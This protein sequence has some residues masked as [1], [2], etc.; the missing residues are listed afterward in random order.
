VR[1]K[2][3][4]TEDGPR[5][6]SGMYARVLL[7]TGERQ[8]ATLVNKDALVLGGPQPIVFVVD[9]AAAAK[10]GKVRPVPVKLGTA[11]ENFIQV[12]GALQPGQ[13]V[14]VQG[15]ERLQPGQDVRFPG[16]ASP[17]AGATQESPPVGTQSNTQ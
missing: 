9:A 1:V 8:M 16:V 11:K 4:I 10:Q 12:I 5:L 13:I 14:V 2:N 6:K 7:P 17:P 3:E 15:N